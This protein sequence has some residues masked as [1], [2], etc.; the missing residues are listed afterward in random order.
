MKNKKATLLFCIMAI[1]IA[2]SITRCSHNASEVRE[3]KAVSNY[4]RD[5][6]SM[7]SDKLGRV[8]AQRT[9]LIADAKDLEKINEQLYK[10]LKV[11]KKTKFITKT[12][13]RYKTDTLYKDNNFTVLSDSVLS[14][15]NF[16]LGTIIVGYDTRNRLFAKSTNPNVVIDSLDGVLLTDKPRR[17]G[18]GFFVGPSV[19][20]G[21]L[22]RNLDFGVS[23]G[24]GLTWNIK[25]GRK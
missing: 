1:V 18:I 25:K 9:M 20:Y 14:D 15:V 7:Y 13:V 16:D 8:S 3:W 22:G 23:A 12:S 6:V 5:T 10:E 21:V 17:L 19:G 2:L 11:E 4:L 24:V